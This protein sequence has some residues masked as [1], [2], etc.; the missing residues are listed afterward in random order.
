MNKSLSL[1]IMLT[2]FAA[3]V[4]SGETNPVTDKPSF[5][6]SQS[7]TVSARVEAIN[8]KTREVTLRKNDGNTESFIATD[9]ARNL[10][11]VKVGDIVIAK[12]I[13]S[14]DIEVVSVENASAQ[15]GSA[16]ALVRSEKGE[17][18][19]ITEVDTTVTTAIVEEINLGANTF[20]LK[21]PEG[22]ITEHT[23]RNPENLK[24]VAVGDMVVITHTST[25][26]LTVEQKK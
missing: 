12:Y 10:D 19:S 5:S 18:P 8:H 2:L 14:L 24:K 25:I 15:T 16:M 21:G 11:Q 22:N 17:M 9:E 13:E 6:A 26:S 20:K 7:A 4:W 1:W 3:P 23:A